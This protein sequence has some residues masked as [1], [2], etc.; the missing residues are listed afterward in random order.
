MWL[1]RIIQERGDEGISASAA[2]E[3]LKAGLISA[4]AQLPYQLEQLL[5]HLQA[6]RFIVQVSKVFYLKLTCVSGCLRHLESELWHGFG[7]HS[8]IPCKHSRRCFTCA[9]KKSRPA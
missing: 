9:Q 2:G 6:K 3:K 7:I 8:Q 1:Y 4:P 5:D